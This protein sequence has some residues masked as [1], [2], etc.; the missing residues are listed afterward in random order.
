MYSLQT[1]IPHLYYSTHPSRLLNSLPTH[2]A[3]PR[4]SRLRSSTGPRCSSN[5]SIPSLGNTIRCRRQNLRSSHW[6]LIG[7]SAPNSKNSYQFWYALT[8]HFMMELAKSPCPKA[9]DL[10]PCLPWRILKNSEEWGKGK[11]PPP[12]QCWKMLEVGKQK[13]SLTHLASLVNALVLASFWDELLAAAVLGGSGGFRSSRL[14]PLVAMTSH[15]W[16]KSSKSRDCIL[17]AFPPPRPNT[18]QFPIKDPKIIDSPGITR[19]SMGWKKNPSAIHLWLA[20][21]LHAAKEF[22]G[23]LSWLGWTAAWQSK[24]L[25]SITLSD[26]RRTSTFLRKMWV[27]DVYSLAW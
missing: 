15:N 10:S 2:T 5:F 3:L 23:H 9:D 19:F 25:Q 20:Q 17:Q 26:W 18:S 27:P 11:S 12:T 7:S 16:E 4:L 14:N 22:A 24:G 13:A 8:Q 1:T 6:R 21:W